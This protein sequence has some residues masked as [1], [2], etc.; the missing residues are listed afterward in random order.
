M[1]YR[2]VLFGLAVL[3]VTVGLSLARNPEVR[4]KAKG[5]KERVEPG[6]TGTVTVT[7]KNRTSET[8]E[9][10]VTLRYR[11]LEDEPPIAVANV[12]LGPKEKVLRDFEVAVPGD[13]F[14]RRLRV[15]ASI[16]DADAKAKLKTLRSEFT[17]ELWLRGEALYREECGTRCHG[18]RGGT[19]KRRSLASWIDAMRSGPKSMPRYP[20]VPRSD[21]VL[22]RQYARDAKRTVD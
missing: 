6:G 11:D 9:V 7:L 5:G 2:I 21:I 8:R 17:D 19:V 22:M 14:D 20:D 4:I 10:A 13:W 18:S 1:K 15:I 3:G 16:P 12:S